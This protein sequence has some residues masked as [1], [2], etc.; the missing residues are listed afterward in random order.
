MSLEVDLSVM[1]DEMQ[2]SMHL[3]KCN[4]MVDGDCQLSGGLR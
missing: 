4:N 3:A 1:P 2:L